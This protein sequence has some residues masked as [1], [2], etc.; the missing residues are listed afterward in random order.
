MQGLTCNP[1]KMKYT[2]PK[3]V[4]EMKTQLPKEV[5]PSRNVQLSADPIISRASIP[6]EHRSYQW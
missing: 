4:T 5:M 2:A 1:A 3:E 6:Q